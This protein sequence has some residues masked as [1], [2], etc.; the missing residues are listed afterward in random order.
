M[1]GFQ[2][3][4]EDISNTESLLIKMYSVEPE[5]LKDDARV[6]L[7]KATRVLSSRLETPW[8]FVQRTTW[9]EVGVLSNISTRLNHDL[10]V[11]VPI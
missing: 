4:F 8:E 5:A 7:L 3:L 1:A 6:K 10:S 11:A 2:D 9:E